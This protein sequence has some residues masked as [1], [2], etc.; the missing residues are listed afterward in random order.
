M[1]L[2]IYCQTAEATTR[3]H[4]PPK[5]LFKKPRPANL[6]AV[7][8]CAGCNSAFQKDDEYFLTL[9]LE[10]RAQNTPA[11]LAVADN[12]IRSMNRPD[13]GSSGLWQPIFKSLRTVELVSP[14]GLYLGNTLSLN[15]DV[16]RLSATVNRIIRGLYFHHAAVPIPVQTKVSSLPY[17]HYCKLP[18]TEPDLLDFPTM[19]AALKCWSIGDS[20]FRYWFAPS[21]GEAVSS[22]WCLEFYRS[23]AFVGSTGHAT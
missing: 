6:V 8:A 21:D 17:E 11:A 3:D 13:R 23:V 19:L 16:A 2:C 5:A 20:E 18:Q 9:S 4:V 7:P 10:I 1:Q 15:L 14:G 12:R 22:F